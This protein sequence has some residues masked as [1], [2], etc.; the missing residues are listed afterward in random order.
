M[1]RYIELALGAEIT[2]SSPPELEVM[3]PR[4]R[5]SCHSTLPHDS[6][7][8]FRTADH[9][10][11]SSIVQAITSK[12]PTDI[13]GA[14]R[15]SSVVQ[16]LVDLFNDSPSGMGLKTVSPSTRLKGFRVIVRRI[17]HSPRIEIIL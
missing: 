1:S 16:F 13:I 4:L 2:R 12:W 14:G 6:H 17:A 8:V 7:L 9:P 11:G 10:V 5:V 15:I 3:S